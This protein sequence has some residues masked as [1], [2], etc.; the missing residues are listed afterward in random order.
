M[1][2]AKLWYH[3]QWFA[4]YVPDPDIEGEKLEERLAAH[5]AAESHH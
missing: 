2:Q 3:P 5:G 1:V 4:R